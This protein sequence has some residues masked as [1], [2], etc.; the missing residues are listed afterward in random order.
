MSVR[1]ALRALNATMPNAPRRSRARIRWAVDFHDGAKNRIKWFDGLAGEQPARDYA[2][3]VAGE[4]RRY[5]VT[6]ATLVIA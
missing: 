2:A 3:T 4:V 5:R 1:D 6:G